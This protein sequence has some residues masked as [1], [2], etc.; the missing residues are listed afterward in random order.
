VIHLEDRDVGE[1][2][3]L[4]ATTDALEAAFGELGRGE[5]ATTTRVRA[6]V[7]SSMASGMAAIVP[8]AGISGGKLY[9][10]HPGG[11]SFVVA[12][13]STDGGV[14]CTLDGD[15]L[16]RIRTAAA[17][18]LAV[19]RLAPS[20][21]RV[22]ALFGTGNQSRWQA[23]ALAQ[24]LELDE[25]RIWGRSAQ[26]VDEL[27][28]W[29][30]GQGLPARALSDPGDAV[31]GAGVVVA[32]TSSYTPVFPGERLGDDVLVCGVGSTKAERRE[33]DGATVAKAALI[34]TDSC[35]GA[36]VECGDLIQAQREGL[37]DLSDVRELSDVVCGRV[38]RPD[39]GVVLFESQGIAL[40]DV[41]GAGL[42]Y[43][44]WM[45]R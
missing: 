5:A 8:A 43:R 30:R 36:V 25:L 32:V 13:F 21:A 24:E 26:P 11:F 44:A 1:L 34:V 37:V 15:M 33:L 31:D 14:L 41:V 9:G 2:L 35:D 7:G 29:A 23:Q 17:T 16:T 3:D 12:L 45:A 27:T 22:A 42:A 28:E 20:G 18:A 6:S 39:H 38:A 40:E 19:R 10:T 4:R